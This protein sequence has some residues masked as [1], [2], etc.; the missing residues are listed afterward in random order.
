M[1]QVAGLVGGATVA[2]VL[3]SSSAGAQQVMWKDNP[4]TGKVVGLTYG[5]S[6]WNAAET[7]AI[8]YGGHLLTLRNQ[9][10]YDWVRSQFQANWGSPLFFGDGPWIGLSDADQDG[11][12]SWSSGESPNWQ[13]PWCAGSPPNQAGERYAH[14]WTAAS[15]WCWDDASEARPFRSLIEVAQRPP[16]S[17]SWPTAFTTGAGPNNGCTFDMDS[18]GDL[19]YAS[20]DRE[21]GQISIWRNNGIGGFTLA[22]TVGGC[23]RPHTIVP[24]DWNLDGDIDLLCSDVNNN[25]G[26]LLY[27]RNLGANWVLQSLATVP[28]CHGLSVGDVNRDGQVDIVTTSDGTDNHTRIF[29][30]QSDGALAAPVLYGPFFGPAYQPKLADLDLDGHL[31]LI[32]AG[33]GVRLLR[34]SGSGAF[35]DC[36]SLG[37]GSSVRCT[38]ADLDADGRYEI[39][40]SREGLDVVEVWKS[41]I[42]GPLAVSNYNLIQSS[43]CGD[44]PRWVETGDVDGDGDLDVVVP[45]NV[46]DTVHILRNTPA[47]LVQDH[48]LID[49]DYATHTVIVDLNGDAKPDILTSNYFANAFSVHFNQ[50]I[51]DCNGNGLDD[52]LDITSGAATDCNSNGR[53]DSCEPLTP[54]TDCDGNGTLDACQPLTSAN[55]CNANGQLDICET[56]AGTALDCN[57]NSRPDSCDLAA[58]APDCNLNQVPDSCDIGTGASLDGDFNN[59][60]DEC[61]LDCNGNG[62]LDS[63]ECAQGLVADCN[64]N[65]VPDSCDVAGSVPDC[66]AN[67]VPDSC[68]LASGTPD[69]N[70]NS[71]PDACDLAAGAADCN[72][73]QRPD[74]C[75]LASGAPD[76]DGNLVPDSCQPLTSANDCDANGLLDA[77]DLAAG[78]ADCNADAIPDACQP[79]A[80]ND[81]VMDE[82]Q[83]GGLPYC[84][85][86]GAANSTPCPCGGVGAPRSGCPNSADAR[87]AYLEAIGLPSRTADSLVLRGS[88]MPPVA[89]M[90]Y[91][92]GTSQAVATGPG[93]IGTAFGDGL[94]CAAGAVVRLGFRT[95][96]NGASQ[97]PSN[98]STPLHVA[99]QIPTSG[100]VTRYYQGWYRDVNPNFC[101]TNRY[102]LTNGVAVV[103]VP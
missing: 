67:G 83:D 56:T 97:I 63:A 84:F 47:G 34:G 61:S 18:D 62:L 16:R 43:P 8:A 9:Q 39:I 26:R 6:G 3:G 87:G 33:G 12:W 53:P 51:S 41:L 103:W 71:I 89:T 76:C 65:L 93:T 74:S 22:T 11:S 86:D 57:L 68:D 5:T 88:Q 59:I 14:P 40:A 7:Q 52:S 69:C 23:G 102:N 99:G 66:N 85:G 38:A 30:R 72:A 2:I 42:S 44:G 91:F 55:D 48:V 46:S 45:S 70:G 1:K 77:C 101:T 78:A 79:D 96:V 37:K 27:V 58:G 36:G 29:L 81:G 19:D 60:P 32:V 4:I 25:G 24:I 35:F 49:Q 20:P 80:N 73:N 15:S 75:D 50:S 10:E 21:G 98:G 13:Y 94:R 100:A 28:F 17:W 64:A 54:Q 92:Q 90:L 31:D 95:N 82:C